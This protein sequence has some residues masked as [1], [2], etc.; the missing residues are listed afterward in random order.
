MASS[1]LENPEK[2]L[3]Q[4]LSEQSVLIVDTVSSARINLATTLS[5]M[6]ANRQ[7]MTLVESIPEARKIIKRLKPK[8]VFTDFTVGAESGLDLLQE[9]KGAYSKSELSE[10]IFVL[11][12]SNSSQSAVARAAEEDVDTFIIKPYT[13]ELLRKNLAITVHQKLNPSRYLQLIEEGKN[14]LFQ[15][16][17]DE[18]IQI[19]E[20]AMGES[21]EP[22]LACFYAGQAEFMK[23]AMSRAET[24]YEK[25]LSYNKIHY[26][27]LVGLFDLL[28]MQEK[29]NE[30]YGII[31][32]LAQYFPANPKRLNS[33]LR[34]AIL[35][36]NFDDIEGYYQIYLLI[37]ERSD[38]LTKHMCSALV[39][40]GKHYL[41]KDLN[42]RALQIFESAAISSA[43]R[44]QF[45]AYIIATLFD[46]N[47]G[48]EVKPFWDRLQKCTLEGKDYYLSKFFISTL[49]DSPTDS[50]ELG[51]KLIADGYE[52]AAVYQKLIQLAVKS[53]Q[54]KLVDEFYAAAL[55]KWPD[56]SEEF[57]FAKFK[58]Q[59]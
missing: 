12:T 6:G 53:K 23:S 38:D 2:T 31:R 47:L 14:F 27:C 52:S 57:D 21:P 8:L 22:T 41:Q 44:T 54:R 59:D 46:Y 35:T 48:Q 49:N 18:A 37:T 5:S 40:A 55:E 9:Q 50:I 1:S 7:N 25:G 11:L 56:K 43:G 13:K 58:I 10:T 26:K 20:E 4:Y 39:V 17:Y 33:V 45:L 3:K 16:K 24:K 51:Q 28:M 29:Y 32:K 42:A 19:F 15:N 36:D 34:V 30:A